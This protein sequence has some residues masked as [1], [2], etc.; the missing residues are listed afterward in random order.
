MWWQFVPLWENFYHCQER[1]SYQ[2]YNNEDI[3]NL[4]DTME[5]NVKQLS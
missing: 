1:A 5:K 2:D 4:K 3:T